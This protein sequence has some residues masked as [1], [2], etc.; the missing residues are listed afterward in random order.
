MRVD[1]G[2]GKERDRERVRVVPSGK[3]REEGNL[4][5]GSGLGRIVGDQIVNYKYF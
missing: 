5:S 2:E 1:S 4:K 3:R